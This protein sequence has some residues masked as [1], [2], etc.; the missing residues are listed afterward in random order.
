M[1]KFSL[2]SFLHMSKI[3]VLVLPSDRTGVGKFRSLDPHIKLNEM[4]GDE[5]EVDINYEPDFSDEFL[6]QYDIIHA[7]RTL[8]SYET[9]PETLK[10]LRTL[11]VKCILDLDDYWAPGVE[12]PAYHL[13]HWVEY[14]H[15]YL[16]L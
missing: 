14:D 15:S 6:T 12:H 4:F 13:Q 7:H 11:G 16:T 3:K 5:F 2:N 10:R 1:L 8:G 9:A